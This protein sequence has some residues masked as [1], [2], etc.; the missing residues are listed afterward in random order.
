MRPVSP[1][2]GDDSRIKRAF[3]AGSNNALVRAAAGLG[4]CGVG[5]FRQVTLGLVYRLEP[6][7]SRPGHAH[8][9]R[10]FGC[11]M[12]QVRAGFGRGYGSMVGSRRF[13]S[14]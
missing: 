8:V 14:A 11:A 12:P 6:I 9:S 4:L 10:L 7:H 13:F 3:R 1:E 2:L 5:L